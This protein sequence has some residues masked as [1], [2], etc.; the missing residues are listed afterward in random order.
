[1]F[2]DEERAVWWFQAIYWPDGRACGHCGSTDTKETPKRLPMPYRCRDCGRYFSVRTGTVLQSSRLPLRKWAFA[3]YI[4][5][6]N[7]KSV[8]SMKLARDLRVTQKTAWFMLH[9]LREAWDASGLEKLVGPVEVD[10]SYFGGL[11]KNMAKSRRAKLEGHGTV[12]KTAVV[13]IRDRASNKVR[14]QVVRDTTGATLKGFVTENA[15]SPVACAPDP[16]RPGLSPGSTSYPPRR[17]KRAGS[18]SEVKAEL[19]WAIGLQLLAQ[20]QLPS[21]P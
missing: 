4:Y 16:Q 9:R 21:R 1:M 13:G 11:R 10:E 3:V 19:K 14:A 20:D 6:T 7:L 2:P 5:V 18:Y 12:G 8:S 17:P 15:A